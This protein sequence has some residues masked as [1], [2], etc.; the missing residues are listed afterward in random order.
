M[1]RGTVFG[2]VC[3]CVFLSVCLSYAC[4]SFWKHRPIQKLHFFQY[5]G[6]SSDYLGHFPMLRSSQTAHER[7]GIELSIRQRED[8]IIS[9]YVHLSNQLNN[10]NEFWTIRKKLICV[11]FCFKS[12]ILKYSIIKTH[13][14]VTY[15]YLFTHSAPHWFQISNGV[16]WMNDLVTI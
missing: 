6:A 9:D 3:L 11:F 7:F 1:R 8:N 15:A 14:I 2:R 12:C 5:A 10:I 13:E 4:A 16:V